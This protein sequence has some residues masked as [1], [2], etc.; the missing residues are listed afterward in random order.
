MQDHEVYTDFLLPTAKT[1]SLMTYLKLAAVKGWDL[2]KVDVDGACLCAP[3]NDEQ[4]VF[5]I[6]ERDL[7]S[8]VVEGES[9]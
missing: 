1:R 4:E 2:L 9:Q 6:Q 8:M 5:M 7:T 3:I